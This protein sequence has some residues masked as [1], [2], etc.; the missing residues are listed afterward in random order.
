MKKF[1]LVL[2]FLL[3]SVASPVFAYEHV[4]NNVDLLS[5]ET[6]VEIENQSKLTEL[7]TSVKVK[8]VLSENLSE[9]AY[10]K[11]LKDQIKNMDTDKYIIV[12]LVKNSSTLDFYIE[13]SD[14]VKKKTDEFDMGFVI[15]DAREDIL[16]LGLNIGILNTAKSIDRKLN[17]YSEELM[18]AK[19]TSQSPL[20]LLPKMIKAF[21]VIIFIIGYIFRKASKIKKAKF[22]ISFKSKKGNENNTYERYINET[23]AEDYINKS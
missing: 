9:K 15:D 18:S 12:N 4:E 10:E 17:L 5:N 23:S 21:G 2:F 8:Y 6:I 7:N 19:D 14:L 13:Y 1:V 16:N 20:K 22:K 11:A 3:F